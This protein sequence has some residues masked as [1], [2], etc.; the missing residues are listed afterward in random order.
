MSLL[1]PYEL[2]ELSRYEDQDMIER[3]MSEGGHYYVELLGCELFFSPTVAT[4]LSL[5]LVMP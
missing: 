5:G 4:P 2:P 3:G 1:S